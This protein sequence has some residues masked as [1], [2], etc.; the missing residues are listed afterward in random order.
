MKKILVVDDI[1]QNILLLELLFQ[2][3]GYEV[4]TAYNGKEAL[5]CANDTRPD[6]II[7]DILMPT[8]D[9]YAFCRELKKDPDLKTIPFIFYSAT[10]TDPKDKDF[11]LSLGADRFIVKPV[12]PELFLKTVTEL[13]GEYEK[14]KAPH[15]DEEP[16]SEPDYQKNYSERLVV[17]LEKKMLDLQKTNQ[18]LQDE[19]AKRVK[20][21][22]LW[23]KT[24]NSID[25]LLMIQDENMNILEVNDATLRFFNAT[26]EDLVGKKCYSV[27]CETDHPCDFC[28]E[29]DTVKDYQT[30]SQIMKLERLKKIFL[31]SASVITSSEGEFEYLVHL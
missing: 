1:A 29:L 19:I 21:E 31:V 2:K 30:R 27:F 10:Y 5:Q 18:E 14:G 8:M 20:L 9:G 22:N 7:S 24:V 26:P 6:L 28:P 13:L 15:L 16:S 4:L 23:E 25:D 11:A 17:K 3:Q 12:L